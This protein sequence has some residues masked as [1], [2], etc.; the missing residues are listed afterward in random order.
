MCIKAE[1]L[2]LVLIALASINTSR[3]FTVPTCTLSSFTS[4][5]AGTKILHESSGF[6]CSH[7]TGLRN[8]LA[9]PRVQSKSILNMLVDVPLQVLVTGAAGKTGFFTFKVVFL[10]VARFEVFR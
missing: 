9:S 6:A 4:L 7:R 3:A 2:R 10:F 5:K 1:A 8:L